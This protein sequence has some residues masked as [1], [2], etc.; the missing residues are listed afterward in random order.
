MSEV[1]EQREEGAD[2]VDIEGEKERD[3][4]AGIET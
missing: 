4:E 2:M 3:M 1:Y